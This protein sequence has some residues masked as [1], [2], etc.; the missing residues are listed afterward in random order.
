MQWNIPSCFHCRHQRWFNLKLTGLADTKVY[1]F[2]IFPGLSWKYFSVCCRN[3]SSS[4][5]GIKTRRTSI[6]DKAERINRKSKEGGVA[7]LPT[8]LH[9]QEPLW[10]CYRKLKV[11]TIHQY[12]QLIVKQAAFYRLK[13]HYENSERSTFPPLRLLYITALK[14]ERRVCVIALSHTFP[15]RL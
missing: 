6:T 14:D 2:H 1:I 7:V 8:M 9:W 11:I 10:E 15:S 3:T 13:H 5:F 4:L 12:D